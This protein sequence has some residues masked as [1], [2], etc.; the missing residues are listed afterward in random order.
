MDRSFLSNPTLIAASKNFICIRTATYEDANEAE[1]LRKVYSGREGQLDNTVFALLSPD[2]QTNLSRTGRS[3]Q[4]FYRSPEAMAAAMDVLAFGYQGNPATE[5]TSLPVMKNVRLAVNVAACDGLP[6][7]IVYG[8]DQEQL[9]AMEKEL[10]PLALS[11][12]L[13]GKLIYAK[14]CDP[15][16]V[17]GIAGFNS[18]Q[19]GFAVVTPDQY[20]VNGKSQHQWPSAI[21]QEQLQAG[22]LAFVNATSKVQKNH[23]QHVRAGRNQGIYWETEIPVEDKMSQRAMQRPPQR[24]K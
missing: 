7:M 14:T 1:F 2:G 19:F 5:I 23:N 16:E 20:G 9:R 21:K 3:P 11:E 13:S 17:E 6:L 4:F 24:D 15:K 10:L 22:L 8:K 12:Q 18:G